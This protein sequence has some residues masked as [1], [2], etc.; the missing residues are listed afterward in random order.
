MKL[1]RILSAI[2]LVCM[3]IPM[4]VINVG[5]SEAPVLTVNNYTV[6]V[7][8]ADDIKDMRY[9]LGEY[10]TVAEIKAAP[11]N[12]ALSEKV[13]ANNTANGVFTY[14]MP[15]AGYYTFWVRMKD[16]T[17]YFLACDMTVIN[18]SV[19]SYGVMVTLHDLHDVKDFFIAK[20][21]YNDYDEIKDNGY[22]VRVTSAKLGDKH[23]YTY[24][25]STPGMHTVLIRYN[26]GTEVVFHEELTVDL[27]VFTG[28]GLQLIISN[29]PDVKVIRTAYGSYNTPGE[30]KRAAGSRSYSAKS[31]IK[32]AESY[33]IQYREEGLVSVVVQYNNGFTKAFQYNVYHKEPT[34]TQ[35]DDLVSFSELDGLQVIRYAKGVY[36]TSNEIK[37]AEGSQYIRP[38]AAVGGVITVE[39]EPGTYTFCVQ[40]NDDSY[41]YYVIT[42]EDHSAPCE[43]VWGDWAVITEPTYKTEGV[44]ERECT[45]CGETESRTIPVLVCTH[46]FCDWY[47]TKPATEEEEG[48]ERRDC[49]ICGETETRAIPTLEAVPTPTATGVS[50]SSA[51]TDNMVLQRDEALSV[52]G[53]ANADSGAVVV[54]LNGKYAW[55]KV[56]E[57]GVWKATFAET[58]PYSTET[59]TITVMSAEEDIVIKDVLIGDVYF[60]IGQSNV[61]YSMT[62]LTTELEERGEAFSVDYDDSK[63][64]RFFRISAMDY[65]DQTGVF[66]QGTDT[67]YYDVYTGRPWQKPSDIGYDVANL[68]DNTYS[69][70]GYLFAYEMVGKS[71]VP[72]GVIEIDA[73]GTSLTGFAPN[74]L[75]EKWGQETYDYQ[76]GTYHYKLDDI[77]DDASISRFM[78]NQ[79]I[80]PVSGFSTAGLIWYQGES[81]WYNVRERHGGAYCEDYYVPQ[82]VELINYYRSTFGNSDFPVYI[83]EFPPCYPGTENAYIDYGEIRAEMGN[84]P[85]YLSDCYIVS[86]SDTWFDHSW[87]NNIHPPIKQYQASRLT[88]LV[89]AEKGISSE[90]LEDVHGPNIKTVEYTSTGATLT[91][92]HVGQGICVAH[93]GILGTEVRGLEARVMYNG[94][95]QWITVSNVQFVDANTLSFDIGQEIYGVRYHA[96]TNANSPYDANLCNS[97]G[98]PAIA[99]S[100]YCEKVIPEP[101]PDSVVPTA[102]NVRVAKAF[103]DNMVLQ[104]DQPLSV[105]GFGDPGGT[106]VV[107]LGGRNACAQVGRDGTWKATFEEGFAYNYF[108]Q[109]LTIRSGGNDIVIKDVLIG[110]VYF[111]IGQSNVY[112]SLAEQKIDLTQRNMSYA[113]DYLDYN[114]ARSIRFFRVSADD[115]SSGAGAAAKGTKIKY[116][117]LYNGQKWMMPSEIGAQVAEYTK[118]IPQ[119]QDYNRNGISGKVFSALGYQF[120]FNMCTKSVIPVG[121]IQ[122]DASGCP[123]ITF[124]P[125]ELANKWGHEAQDSDGKYYYKLNNY[126]ENPSQKTRFAYNQMIYPLSGFSIAGIIWYQGESDQYNTRE[127]W[128]YNYDNGFANQFAELMTYFRSTFGNSDFPVYM[129]EYPTCFYNNNN[130]LFMDF[131]G[132]RAELGTIPQLLPETYIISSSDLWYDNTWWNNIHPY[133]KYAQA[134][135]LSEAVYQYHTM[136]SNLELVV[137]PTLKDVDYVNAHKAILTFDHVGF[138]LTT[139]YGNGNVLGIEIL[140]DVN[141]QL[142]W[143]PHEGEI[144]TGHD[145]ITIDAGT[146][147]LY[148]VRYNARTEARFPQQLTLCNSYNMPAIAFVD[149]RTE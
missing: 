18:A 124:A 99:F 71:D 16:G 56:D 130:N 41:N 24:T 95:P 36:E 1:K 149:Y 52:W 102:T 46:S 110:D 40:Y 51:F 105:W 94:Y 114:D 140:I 67:I 75:A 106:V 49:F 8:C 63:N 9:A 145:T 83:M 74:H 129:I 55:A 60:M 98:M 137:G 135:R 58:F 82:Y 142:V 90:S 21:Q 3:L 19:T 143:H 87:E 61:F 96:I 2:L 134:S 33:T 144:I 113:M 118:E 53:L 133:I 120:A 7:T 5:A 66:A 31:D 57:H 50:V 25:V 11:G 103:S 146:F 12:V 80:Y 64:M 123:L 139:A 59:T 79:A 34:V 70:L 43:H 72:V 77:E 35:D 92:D 126:V 14:T 111:L 121:V 148:G 88:A 85:N 37:N 125:N 68:V 15:E 93:P 6:T 122:I 42:V 116:N 32:G 54:E 136:K 22:I 48:E 89:C 101:I 26:D 45:L 76:L 127:I 112:Y 78:Y 86:S 97:Y 20:G 73:A 132:V 119:N 4:T 100:D 30:I 65:A 141:G 29:I 10:S 62:M 147:D 108:K 17:N 69:A 39:L 47:E 117:D 23:D 28:N 27:P 81:D 13:V 104:R 109:P 38:S 84:I 91:F 115:F 44:E 131:G 128:G 107:N 138:G